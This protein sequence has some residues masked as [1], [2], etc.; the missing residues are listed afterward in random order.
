MLHQYVKVDYDNSDNDDDNDYDSVVPFADDNL[1][2]NNT[3][4][5]KT[6]SGNISSNKH[7]RCK[8]SFSS[9]VTISTEFSGLSNFLAI[10]RRC[11][12]ISSHF[13]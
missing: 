11:F 5:I 10:S 1:P 12:I 9:I 13:E 6:A 3:I 8:Y 7:P 4:N 2:E